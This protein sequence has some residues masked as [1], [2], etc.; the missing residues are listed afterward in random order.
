[1]IPFIVWQYVIGNFWTSL[2][3]LTL[4][5]LTD[6]CDG[7]IARKFNMISTAGKLIDPLAD[8][9]TQAAVIICISTKHPAF[10]LLVIIFCSKE[11]AQLLAA[12]QL[13]K[14]GKRPSEAKWWGKMTTVVLYCIVGI[15]FL[16][17]A[18]GIKGYENYLSILVVIGCIC[19]VFALFQYYPIF[20]AIISGKYDI[21]TE[22][23]VDERAALKK[24][25]PSKDPQTQKILTDEFSDKE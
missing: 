15:L 19:V 1:M 24:D 16:Y 18:F 8:K 11:L 12:T 10:L 13:L 7:I 20:K 3:L 14:L 25:K 9:L 2:I 4:S 17:D 6:V 5:G 21:E 22:N 23:Y